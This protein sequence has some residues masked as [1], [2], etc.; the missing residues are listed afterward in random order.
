MPMPHPDPFRTIVLAI[1]AAILL[2]CAR[3]GSAS[4]APTNEE[5]EPVQKAIAA[6]DP[7]ALTQTDQLV[8]KFPRWPSGQREL[9]KQQLRA[10][11]LEAALASATTALGL[12]GGEIEAACVQ[13]QAL[14]GLGRTTEAYAVLERVTAKD[15]GGWLHFYAAKVAVEADDLPKA[16][17]FLRQAKDHAVNAVPA[18][19]SFLESRVALGKKDYDGAKSALEHVTA[20]ESTFI[21][22]WYELARVEMM[23]AR[24]YPER[25]KDLLLAA[26]A[27]LDRVLKA[28][29]TDANALYGMGLSRY[30]QG[31]M[32][33]AQQNEDSGR[34][35][36]R[37]SVGFLRQALE[38]RQ[39]FVEPTFILG[40]ALAQLEQY[41]EA[42]PFLKSAREH[43]HSDRGSL[44]NLALAL[45]KVGRKDEAKAILDQTQA[46][47][48]SEQI[49]VGIN[50]YHQ[51]DYLLAAKL[52]EH[53][54]TQL[55]EDP[56]RKGAVLRFLGH[57]QRVLAEQKAKTPEERAEYLDAAKKA[58]GEAGDLHDWKA[59]SF[60]LASE[61]ARD[62]D[63]AYAA[64]WRFLAWKKWLVPQ[65]YGVVL[66]NYGGHLTGG[67]GFSGA[68][69]RHPFHVAVWGSL[70]ALSL[71]GFIAAKLKRVRREPD[72]DRASERPART[73]S[74]PA[75]TPVKKGGAALPPRKPKPRTAE[76]ETSPRPKEKEKPPEDARAVGQR[77][78]E[79]GPTLDPHATG[80]LERKPP[81]RR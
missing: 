59:Q 2:S 13:V 17:G 60:Y 3:L 16:E 51:H 5:W 67:R 76:T 53:V 27:H 26:D 18:E 20:K 35:R 7:A 72:R 81:G 47:T 12:D 38:Q 64:G 69:A 37:E 30:E 54:A 32:A 62:A 22:A 74:A 11:D 61:T 75:P 70:A 52:F 40:N 78:T 29:P 23:L 45:E 63:A 71:L 31:K 48:P 41:E 34:A 24:M 50:A 77:T 55:D 46:V 15:K 33:L 44:F 6:N 21:D 65:G 80:A 79:I 58:Y 68:W 8:Q 28:K 66:G 1:S 43:G 4:D 19:F 57:A 56:E 14:A 42:I 10:G 36:L 73:P 39:D 49:T 9:A 25:A